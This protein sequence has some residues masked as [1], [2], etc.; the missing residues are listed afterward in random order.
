MSKPVDK[1]DFWKGRIESAKAA[2]Q[3]HW[4]VYLVNSFKDIDKAHKEVL[5]KLGVFEPGLKILDAG[6]GY[7]RNSDWFLD[8]DYTGVD[9]SP[10]FIAEAKQLY[11]SKRFLEANLIA[12]PFED[13]EFDFAVVNSIKDMII[14]NLGKEEWQKM[15][16]ELKRVAKKVVI[17]EYTGPSDYEVIS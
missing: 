1:Q 16:D 6:C 3:M 5:E 15:E 11:P 14:D 8:E 9:F 13:K 7:G 12:L 10:D 2:K 17:L 4:S